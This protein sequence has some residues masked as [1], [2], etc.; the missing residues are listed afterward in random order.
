GRRNIVISRNTLFSAEGVER[1]GSL[2][3]ALDKAR[4]DRPVDIC[5]IG[6]GGIFAEALPSATRLRVT[7]VLADIDGDTYFPE[8]PTQDW[9]VIS[10]HDIPAGPND[11]YP[12]RHVVYERRIG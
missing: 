6:G 11:I 4:Q 10:S 9:K 8:L 2:T 1:A 12:T 7:H 5:V 3:E